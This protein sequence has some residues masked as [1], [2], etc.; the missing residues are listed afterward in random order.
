MCRKISDMSKIRVLI[1]NLDKYNLET[2][3]VSFPD[4]ENLLK[5]VVATFAVFMNAN[6]D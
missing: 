2:K 4:H 6:R 1:Y 3:I 5:E